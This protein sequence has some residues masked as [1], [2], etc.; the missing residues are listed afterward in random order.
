MRLELER[1][2]F[3]FCWLASVPLA[4]GC[5]LLYPSGPTVSYYRLASEKELNNTSLQS[6]LPK[7][8]SVN[9]QAILI[10]RPQVAPYLTR[11]NIVMRFGQAKVTYLEEHRWAEPVQSGIQRLVCDSLQQELPSCDVIAMPCL[12]TAEDALEVCIVVEQFE[13]TSAGEAI[14][15]GRWLLVDYPEQRRLLVRS[16]RIIRTFRYN[17]NDLSN[18]AAA[19]TCAVQSL[20]SEIAKTICC[21]PS[22][23]F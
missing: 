16:F 1:L 18:A 5:L 11:P 19:L 23:S 15:S 8:E 10:A 7:P 4:T 14:F 9:R 6:V 13:I 3:C 17:A 22:A 12:F 20:S 21:L 2:I